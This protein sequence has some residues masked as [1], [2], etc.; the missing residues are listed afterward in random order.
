MEVD[1][2]DIGTDATDR[3]TPQQSDSNGAVQGPTDD[4]P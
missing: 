4:W 2:I 3:P 1:G